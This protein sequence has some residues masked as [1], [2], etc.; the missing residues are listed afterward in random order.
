MLFSS[1]FLSAKSVD[2]G[3]CTWKSIFHHRLELLFEFILNSFFQLFSHR[4][5]KT[6]C[7]LFAKLLMADEKVR[8]R[9]TIRIV[10]HFTT[11]PFFGLDAVAANCASASEQHV[12]P[13]YVLNR[14]PDVEQRM[15]TSFL[16]IVSKLLPIRFQ[17]FLIVI[18]YPFMHYVDFRKRQFG[19]MIFRILK[20]KCL[21]ILCRH[22][23]NQ[24]VPIFLR[25]SGR[26]SARAEI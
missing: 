20:P 25:G 10:H 12:A 18:A 8:T 17:L 26:R 16:A 6:H 15:A 13:P 14:A 19:N 5:L 23:R 24:A 11:L 21:E 7:E 9:R 2:I 4:L 1:G 3:V 22:P